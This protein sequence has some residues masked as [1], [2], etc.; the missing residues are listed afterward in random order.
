MDLSVYLYI[1]IGVVLVGVLIYR[2]VTREKRRRK[3]Y[4]TVGKLGTNS[5]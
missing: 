3:K 1:A 2:I 5:K 4:H